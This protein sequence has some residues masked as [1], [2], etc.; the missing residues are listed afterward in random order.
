LSGLAA[1]YQL[2][3]RAA[4]RTVLGRMLD[5]AAHRG[6]D[7]TAEW[8]RGPAALGISLLHTTP[9][10]R[11]ERQ[12]WVNDRGTVAVALDGRIDNGADL[13]R[14]LA[15]CGVRFDGTTDV[16]VVQRAYERHAEAS[17]RMLLGDFAVAIWD[18]DRQALVCA[19]D[20]LGIRPLCYS[21]TAGTFICASEVAQLFAAGFV[22]PEPN[23][24]FLG[25]LLA[26]RPT[27]LAETLY[28]NINRLP[29]GHHLTVTCE[30]ISVR[31][32]F[33]VEPAKVSY[34]SDEEYA[35]HFLE[36]FELAIAARLRA[37]A[38][39]SV[40]V[41]GGVDSTAIAGVARRVQRGGAQAP[42][43]ELLS[44]TC[45][46][47]ASDERRYVADAVR[48]LGVAIEVVSCDGFVPRPIDDLVSEA[49]DVP[50]APNTSPWELLF[51]RV[52]ATGGRVV[53]WGHGGDEW[54]TGDASHTADLLA[55]GNVRAALRQI[56]SDLFLSREW[57]AEGMRVR[58]AIRSAIMP[59]VPQAVRRASRS[60]RHRA[61]PIWIDRKFARRIDLPER[62]RSTPPDP[63]RYPSA[64]Q[65]AIAA[66]V[67]DGWMV[68]EREL[69]DR[70]NARFA[71]EPR[72]PFHD[73]RI[74][75]F[76]L[77]VPE[78]QRWRGGETKFVLREACGP[79]LPV[80]IRTRRSKADFSHLF[81]E[82]LQRERAGETFASLR[83]A[84]DGYLDAAGARR[85]Y[86]RFEAGSR[87]DL[88]AVWI[89]FTL[90]RWYRTMFHGGLRDRPREDRSERHP[91]R[92]V[93]RPARP[94][95]QET[96]RAARAR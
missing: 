77:G 85:T 28:R 78:A 16:E 30:G 82:M 38:P 86:E 14:Q 73:R 29:P 75:E 19:R 93:G 11:P 43:I 65:R 41:S 27:S 52:K 71:I 69:H 2:D 72:Y 74:V 57:G 34:S 46:H 25:E 10:S 15:A 40:F 96:L 79:L 88:D 39:V 21:A 92:A 42:H 18:A 67:D 3:G 59:L 37:A 48:A 8:C 91:D 49:M 36:L 45:S 62:L 87:R 54:L 64:A 22:Q 51:E 24:G 70:F 32:Y 50:D 55:G 47:P 63:E 76:A 12:P 81:V 58:D 33:E 35:E 9:E 61:V 20:P 7:G 84:A 68:L 4:D 23:A 31:R 53:L 1:I 6:P 66:L 89:M 80:S 56:R 17:F 83:L 60:F 95:H 26:Y 94:V 13:R 5:A 44:L 90:E